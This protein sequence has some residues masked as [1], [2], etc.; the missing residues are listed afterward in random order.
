MQ[1]APGQHHETARQP[2]ATGGGDLPAHRFVV[3]LG[4]GHVCLEEGMGVEVKRAGQK[5]GVLVDLRGAGI[6]LRRHESGLL[7]EWKVRVRLH[8]AHAARV[9]I[10]IPGATE[11]TCLLDD[12]EVSDPVL[13]E[14]YCREHP[15]EAPT[16]DHHCRI[17]DH[18]FPGETGLYERVTVKVLELAL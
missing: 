9:P 12:P 5:L 18:R 16:H 14:V 10:P 11:V 17:L 2:I 7:E 15:G 8:I 13:A 4:T 6:A 3:P 1:D